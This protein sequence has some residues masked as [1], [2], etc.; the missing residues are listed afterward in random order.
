VIAH[1]SERAGLL[2]AR[3]VLVVGMAPSRAGHD[4]DGPTFGR[5]AS[6]A[7]LDSAA[8]M[9]SLFD[10]VNLLPE[11]P[12]EA[13]SAKWDARPPAGAWEVGD[14]ASLLGADL[15]ERPRRV[16]LMLGDYVADALLFW[17]GVTQPLERFER[18]RGPG[19]CDL[20]RVP[21]PAGTNM[22]WNDPENRARA[23][24]FLT[25]VAFLARTSLPKAPK[26]VG[27]AERTR[28]LTNVIA[29]MNPG[30]W[31]EGCVDWPWVDPPGR[32]QAILRGNSVP[33]AHVSLEA[34][35]G[36]RPSIRHQAL[37]SC[38]RGQHCVN[39]AHLRW[40]TEL[41]NRLDQS[42]R[43]RG[44]IGRVGLETARAVRAEL[45]EISERRGVPLD[46]IARIAGGKAWTDESWETDEDAP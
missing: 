23:E 13:E 39:G 12:G 35:E 28:W 46:A 34:F 9:A 24:E 3:P 25:G 2:A 19:N 32:P 43:G 6:Y 31:P 1:R 18:L 11:W 5:L 33:A 8:E 10:F 42:A 30:D 27:L 44:D 36:R 16:V 29:Y 40:G 45:D 37:H 7:G 22:W 41:E 21:H 14:R 38:D 17:W 4:L 15:A 26:K 20:Y